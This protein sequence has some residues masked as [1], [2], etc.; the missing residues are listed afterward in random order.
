MAKILRQCSE[1][2]IAS[3]QDATTAAI[4]SMK[5]PPFPQGFFILKR[6]FSLAAGVMLVIFTAGQ[7]AGDA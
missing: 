4:V 3:Q 7:Q 2:F 6:P 5:M 1:G